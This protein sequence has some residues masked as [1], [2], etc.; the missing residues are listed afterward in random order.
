VLEVRFQDLIRGDV[1]VS[2][3]GQVVEL[4]GSPPVVLRIHRLMLGMQISGPTEKGNYVVDLSRTVG[5]G[6][7]QLSISGNDWPNVEPLV[8]EISAALQQPRS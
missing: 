6:G 7:V 3:D 5:G 2:F 8:A 4:F 1:I